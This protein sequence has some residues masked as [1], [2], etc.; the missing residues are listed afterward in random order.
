MS[1]CGSP[2]RSIFRNLAALQVTSSAKDRASR[3]SIS[4]SWSPADAPSSAKHSACLATLLAS[5]P[6]FFARALFCFGALESCSSPSAEPW[7]LPHFISLKEKSPSANNLS[8]VSDP[9]GSGTAGTINAG[10]FSGPQDGHPGDLVYL[11]S[12]WLRRNRLPR[13][14][15]LGDEMRQTTRLSRKRSPP[16]DAAATVWSRGES[17]VS[18]VRSHTSGGL[19]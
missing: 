14:M 5:S 3:M 2:R 13:Y 9:P 10:F 11:L 17:P 19:T 12:R 8:A 18:S 1:Y 16:R 15:N 6:F 7:D 4:P